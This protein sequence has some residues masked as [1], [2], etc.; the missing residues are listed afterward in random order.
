M[1]AC[2]IFF[3]K[4]VESMHEKYKTAMC[5]TGLVTL[6]ACYHYFRI[7]N[8]FVESYELKKDCD[9]YDL[10]SFPKG[11]YNCGYKASGQYYNDAYR[12]MDWLLTVPLLLMEIVL[13]MKIESDDEKWKKG[14]MLGAS[15]A[16]MVI[17]GYPGEISS[18]H[19]VRWVF[20][21]LAMCPFIFIV[22][23]L[24]VGL[25]ATAE[26]ESNENLKL[27]CKQACWWTVVS[28]CTYP[29]VYILP[30]LMN[31]TNGE[32]TANNVVGIQIGYSIADVISKCGVGLMVYSI[33]VAKSK[34]Q[35]KAD[36]DGIS[37]EAAATALNDLD[38]ASKTETGSG[39]GMQMSDY[40]SIPSTY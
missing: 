40:G 16:V 34:I 27:L 5:F 17:L 6:I 4:R 30:M 20:W 13:V 21:A 31:T 29:I 7:F 24:L 3:F 26:T 18:S 35:F 2:T 33:S 37:F 14:A 12:Y 10:K 11:N 9:G 19:A 28:W 23:T 32:M 1:G 15:A 25:N 39:S 38:S 36:K 22:Y 8:S